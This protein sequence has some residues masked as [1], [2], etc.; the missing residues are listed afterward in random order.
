MPSELQ[1]VA[2]QLLDTLD[3]I[4]RVANYLHD[5]AGKYREAAGWVGSLSS[6]S[7]ARMAAIQLDEAARR[8]EEASHYL[9]MAP[10]RARSWVE[11]MVSGV[12]IAEPSG[13]VA[14]IS[15]RLNGQELLSRLPVQRAIPNHRQKT[16]GAWQDNSGVIH[17]LVSGRHEEDFDAAVAHAKKLGLIPERGTLGTAADVEL[18]FAMKMRREGITRAEIAVN[19]L[20]CPGRLG[21]NDLLKRF[22]P[23]G[24]ELVIHGPDNFEKTYRGESE[25]S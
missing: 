12:R 18:K 4:P 22:L 1:R 8:C 23:P 19:K 20:P 14:H 11:Q 17:K 7:S 6:N 9:L 2:Q 13:N 16:E 25:T 3:E 15:R 21:C 5:R 24:A 10:P